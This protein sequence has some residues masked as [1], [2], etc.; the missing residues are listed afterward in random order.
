MSSRKKRRIVQIAAGCNPGDAITNEIGILRRFFRR[1]PY[2]DFFQ[3]DLVL[4]EHIAPGNEFSVRKA[5]DFEPRPGDVVLLHYSIASNIAER[6][7]DWD[8]PRFLLY[9][10]VTPSEYFRPYNL[11]I[12]GRLEL[13]S[14]QLRRLAGRLDGYFADSHF[15]ARELRRLGCD[16]VSV[17]PVL[18]P[19]ASDKTPRTGKKTP[20]DHGKNPQRAFRVLF[21][22][23]LVPNKAHADL[24][25]IQFYL[26]KI[27][28]GS[29]LIL[30]GSFFPGMESYRA[31]LENLIRCLGLSRDVEITGYLSPEELERVYSEADLFL[32]TSRHE[33]FCVPLLEAMKYDLPVLG[34][35][36]DSS[37]VQ[38][39]LRGAGL[40]FRPLDHAR[41]AEL[42][43]L[44]LT[45]EALRSRLREG[46]ERRLAEHDMEKIFASFFASLKGMILGRVS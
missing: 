14:A 19:L 3:S 45:D 41:I 35:S 8:V 37:A 36:S 25:K 23:R 6:I 12:A 46:Q 13:A 17:M 16:G 28:P 26:K 9:H 15:N 34:F 33:G 29:R 21:V 27:L 2:S 7:L 11:M 5:A 44:A 40:G 30:A 1:P 20:A 4:A 32:T 24:I 42:V 10:N 39:T 43:A 22:G 38:E 31:E 18:F